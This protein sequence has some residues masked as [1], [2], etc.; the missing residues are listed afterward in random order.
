MEIGIRVSSY[1]E[2]LYKVTSQISRDEIWEINYGEDWKQNVL[3]IAG[4]I[5][6]L[7]ESRETNS[8][9]EIDFS[10]SSAQLLKRMVLVFLKTNTDPV[11]KSKMLDF[12]LVIEDRIEGEMARTAIEHSP[13]VRSWNK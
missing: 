13:I 11:L 4:A 8:E 7:Y 2:D 9:L 3:K 12:I 1:I 10:F 5:E 6:C